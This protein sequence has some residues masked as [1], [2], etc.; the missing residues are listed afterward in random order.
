MIKQFYPDANGL[1]QDDFAR[2]HGAI[3][4]WGWKSEDV[5][6]TVIKI[7]EHLRT[8]GFGFYVLSIT[9]PSEEISFP[10]TVPKPF[11][12]ICRINA[13]VHWDAVPLMMNQRTHFLFIY[14]SSVYIYS[15]ATVIF[16]KGSKSCPLLRNLSVISY[17]SFTFTGLLGSIATFPQFPLSVMQNKAWKCHPR[18]NKAFIPPRPVRVKL[19]IFLRSR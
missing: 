5:A 3:V 11:P 13:K 6:F 4:W 14:H 1:F 19:W 2:T 12:K 18:K 9:T 16:P 8:L 15:Y 7:I 10:R 17:Q